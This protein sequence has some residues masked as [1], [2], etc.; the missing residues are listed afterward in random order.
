MTITN[1]STRLA[2]FATGVVV[3][4]A[5]VSAVVAAPAKALTQAEA[6]AI[7]AALN[8]SGSQAAA[9]NALVTGSGSGS[10]G[11]S[12]PVLTRSLQQ[13][14]T[15]ADVQSLQVFLNASADT[16]VAVSGAGSPGMESM[17]FGPATKAAVIKFQAK[18]NVSPI[19]VV[20]PAT[21]AAIAAVCGSTGGNTGGS[22][23]G[24]GSLQGGEGSLNVEGNLGDVESD[25]D[26][27]EEDVQVFGV[28]LEAEDSDIGLERVDVD[29]TLSGTGSSQLDNYVTE[30]SLWLDGKRIATQDVDEADED[31]DVFS[32]RFTDLSGV[33][34]E[35]ETAELYVAVTAV[36]N[37]D[38]GD[39]AKVLSVDM[40]ADAIRAVDA[41]GISETY[42][43]AS[44]LTAETFSVGEETGGDVDIS[45]GDNNPEAEVV[46]IDEDEDTDDVLVL[47]FEVEVSDQDVVIDAIP[48]G[49]V[50]SGAGAG[51][52]GAVK[53][54]I[55]KMDGEVI[56]TQSIGSTALDG[57]EVLFDNLDIE[58]EDGDTMTFQV[59]V[60][61]N[62][63]DASTFATGTT[64]YA[65]T[66]GSDSHWDVED[67]AGDDV[68]PSGSVSNSG[69]LLVFETEGISV[70]LV[71]VSEEITF[72]GDTT[73]QKQ[74]GEFTI[75]VDITA[76]GEDMY[77]DKSATRTG[78]S[79]AATGTGSA[80]NGFMY[81]TT[82][83]STLG[84]STISA[85]VT[86]SGSTSNDTSTAFK[87]NDGD[88]RRFTLTISSEAQN[89][90]VMAWQLYGIN[91]DTES[92]DTTGDEFY[93][94]NMSDFKT[95]LLTMLVI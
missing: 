73:G 85:V 59:L 67:A 47:E 39:S 9:I 19:G 18:N 60:D 28:E 42:V 68:T 14:S 88:T 65:T 45:E 51:I 38:S 89:D 49:L 17:Y 35:D 1:S 22:T 40:P 3:A 69:E 86:A 31:N 84:T 37:V 12:C 46:T 34:E 77:I 66:T 48:V 26:E 41:E 76:V 23:G 92:S 30:V 27:G 8:L 71:S 64:L 16:R 33:I 70:E 75:V 11:G 6:N 72:E 81:G 74:V 57:I 15:G 43:T 87:I 25:V 20:G 95:D 56:D 61:L 50:S 54:A 53:R 7:I 32:F 94:S 5:L 62:D 24:T 78:T 82:S 4:A 29:I 44:E 93:T 79:G 90:G 63:A 91:W 55:L 13:G 10:T 83:E 80:G 52:D 2:V 36:N 58:A 21:R